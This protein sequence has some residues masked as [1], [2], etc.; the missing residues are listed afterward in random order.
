MALYT[1][2]RAVKKIKGIDDSI[3]LSIPWYSEMK[4]HI[5]CFEDYGG[6]PSIKELTCVLNLPSDIEDTD[7]NYYTIY[8]DYEKKIKD[9]EYYTSVIEKEDL[10]N[11]IVEQEIMFVT[12]DYKLAKEFQT[13]F[14]SDS[15]YFRKEVDEE[16]L[17]STLVQVSSY[18]MF[19]FIV[20]IKELY[21][22]WIFEVHVS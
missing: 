1:G 19:D 10:K 3:L 16:S 20:R 14:G 15:F 11:R 22:D 6:Y 9:Y 5:E 7:E 13:L 4:G 12:R 17:L 21:G 8:P 2:I 18:D